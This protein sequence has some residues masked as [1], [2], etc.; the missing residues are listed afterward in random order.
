MEGGVSP[1][2]FERLQ[3]R[4]ERIRRD[5]SKMDNDIDGL[6]E[7]VAEQNGKIS[8]VLLMMQGL[9]ESVIHLRED[10]DKSFKDVNSTVEKASSI[11]TAIQFASVVIVP[12]LVAVIGGYFALKSGAAR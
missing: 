1:D 11:K 12:I 6:R 7:D 10:L 4:V 3:D 9:T 2:D 5:V 8:T